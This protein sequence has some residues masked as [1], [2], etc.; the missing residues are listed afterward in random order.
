VFL[1]FAFDGILTI[2]SKA[3]SLPS[4][5][6]PGGMTFM[7]FLSW[8]NCPSPH[9]TPWQLISENPDID[10]KY[11]GAAAFRI[12]RR[13]TA[14]KSPIIAYHVTVFIDLFI[15]LEAP[16]N[17]VLVILVEEGGLHLAEVQ[18]ALSSHKSH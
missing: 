9:V 8:Q 1:I 7:H 16:K 13:A 14:T 2:C 11:W 6:V 5:T 4:G 3:Y 10:G 12:G 18:Q 17:K 15:L